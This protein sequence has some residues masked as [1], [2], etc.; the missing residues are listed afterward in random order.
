MMLLTLDQ[1]NALDREDFVAALS[2][3][4]EGPPWIVDQVWA[5]RPFASRDALYDALCHIMF[6]A[7]VERQVALIRAHPDLVGRAALAGTLTPASTAEQAAAGLDQLTP[8]QIAAF[9]RL[10]AEYQQRFGFPFVICARANKTQSILAGFGE[11][12]GHSR[13]KEIATAL[14]EVAK[15]CRLRL[16]D[17]VAADER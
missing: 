12:I 6:D 8:E 5:A 11:R 1:L 3:L 2:G 13:E 15:I 16:M 4:F 9:A 7:P 14:G 10:N 17:T